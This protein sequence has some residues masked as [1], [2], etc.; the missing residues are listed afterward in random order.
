MFQIVR[1][2]KFGDDPTLVSEPC[3][4]YPNTMVRCERGSCHAFESSLDLI[5]L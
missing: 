3:W 2:V 1:K 5:G 4:F